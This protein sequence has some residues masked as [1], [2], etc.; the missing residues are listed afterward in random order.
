[1]FEH[2]VLHCSKVGTSE[3]E[4]TI[5]PKFKHSKYY[6]SSDYLQVLNWAE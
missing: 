1:M 5:M 2:H 4:T 3:L 6:A